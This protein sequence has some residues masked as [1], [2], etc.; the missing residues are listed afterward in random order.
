MKKISNLK[1]KEKRKSHPSV[2]VQA[3]NPRT[4]D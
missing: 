2:V 1:K 3:C 4:R